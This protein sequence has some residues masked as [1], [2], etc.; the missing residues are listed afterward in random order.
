MNTKTL[1]QPTMCTHAHRAHK[2]CACT[3]S[4]QSVRVHIRLT[5][6]ALAHQATRVRAYVVHGICARTSSAQ[7][8][9]C[10]PS[11]RRVRVRITC[12][13]YDRAQQA[14]K[15]CSCTSSAQSTRAHQAREVCA[16]TSDAQRGTSGAQR[17]HQAHSVR[18]RAKRVSARA[19]QAHKVRAC[20]S[21]ARCA[22]AH[23]AY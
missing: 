11:A 8:A 16:C 22:R 12:I 7:S 10:T 4:V 20:R 13:N 15:V 9:R 6:C 2:V 1:I 5:K 17:A 23:Q 18:V 14:R 19:Q 3:S 21:G